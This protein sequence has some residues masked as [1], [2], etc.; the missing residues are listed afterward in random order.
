MRLACFASWKSELNA[1]ASFPDERDANA[2]A[3]LDLSSELPAADW[4][5]DFVFSANSLPIEAATLSGWAA[6]VVANCDTCS[7]APAASGAAVAVAAWLSAGAELDVVA[8]RFT[9]SEAGGG[10]VAAWVG[11]AASP[12]AGFD[13][14]LFAA[15]GVAVLF[16]LSAVVDDEFP[17]PLKKTHE[18]V[19]S[20]TERTIM[21]FI[22]SGGYPANVSLQEGDSGLASR[23]P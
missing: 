22:V 10:V 20:T 9:G 23:L 21:G 15:S 16:A 13:A 2:P 6:A 14:A 5:S 7:T 3:T 18:A 4:A 8:V 11:E 1:L 17:Q 12:V 19:A